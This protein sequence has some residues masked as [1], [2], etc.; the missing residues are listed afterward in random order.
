MS[1]MLTH[2]GDVPYSMSMTLQPSV[3]HLIPYTPGES[4]QAFSQ[5]TGIPPEQV[6]KLNA[7]ESPYGPVPAAL[8]A[9]RTHDWYNQYPDTQAALLKEV[10][11]HYTGLDAGQ[12][13][14]GHGSMEIIRLLWSLF[15]SPGDEI[16]CCPPTFS[17]YTAASS[18]RKAQMRNVPRCPDYELDCAGILQALTPATKLIVLCSPNNPTGNLLAEEELLTLLKTGRMIVVDEAYTEFS[19]KPTGYAHLVPQYRNLVIVRT[20]SKWAGLAG[21]RIGY[22]LFPNWLMTHVQRAH[23]PFA[24][25]VAGHLAATATLTHLDE[26][27]ERVQRIVEERG[28][29][30]Q[31]LAEQSYLEPIPSEGNFILARLSDERVSLHAVQLTME[32]H[33]ILLRYFPH[34]AGHDYVRVTVGLPEHTA[35][36]AEALQDVCTH[37]IEQAE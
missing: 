24:V 9:L 26:A 20:F 30:F 10:L 23:Y 1:T 33:G 12:I 6:I 21:L 5:R 8:S 14:P 35:R 28:R 27:R 4:L 29:L 2:T 16:I 15:L 34:L 17:L 18:E 11:S 31:V 7:N 3:E 22:G 19:R 36:L 32:A 25:N 13:V 37:G